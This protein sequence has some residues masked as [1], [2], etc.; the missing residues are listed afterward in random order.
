MKNRLTLLVVLLFGIIAAYGQD[1]TGP[2]VDSL[3]L[4]LKGSLPDT[5]RLDML[6][7]LAEFYIV[8]PG[9]DKQDL[10]SAADCLKE[11]ALINVKLRS[12]DIR[13]FQSMMASMLA[14]ERK[15]EKQGKEMAEAAVRMLAGS[16]NKYYLGRAYFNLSEYYRYTDRTELVEKIRLVELASQCFAQ[17]KYIESYAYSLKHLADL[18]EINEQRSKVLENLNLSMRLYKSIHY[19]K[20]YG[21]YVLLNRY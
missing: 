7:R 21:V 9:D 15:Q 12:E 20:L 16:P 10:D 8:K 1:L 17:S 18:Y 4:V 11:T 2:Q 13:G 5:A 14:K 19:T 3:R 6:F